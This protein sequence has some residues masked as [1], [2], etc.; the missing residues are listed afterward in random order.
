MRVWVPRKMRSVVPTSS[1]WTSKQIFEGEASKLFGT[2][3]IF[4]SSP[5]SI[6][7][8]SLGCLLANPYQDTHSLAHSQHLSL[9]QTN[10]HSNDHNPTQPSPILLKTHWVSE[11]DLCRPTK[12]QQQQQQKASQHS[13]E[14]NSRQ[15]QKEYKSLAENS[16]QKEKQPNRTASI[17]FDS[18]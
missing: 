6:N 9:S 1:R 5:S 11:R 17:K 3:Q 18:I 10:S 2:N 12:Q 13:L 4:T 8:L 7:F 14:F 15:Q 16:R